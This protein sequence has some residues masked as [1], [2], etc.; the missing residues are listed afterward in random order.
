MQNGK[1]FSK[2]PASTSPAAA[3]EHHGRTALPQQTGCIMRMRSA[4]SCHLC[5][6]LLVRVGEQNPQSNRTSLSVE[7]TPSLLELLSSIMMT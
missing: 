6:I 1:N 3:G 2:K 7:A 5:L 4:K